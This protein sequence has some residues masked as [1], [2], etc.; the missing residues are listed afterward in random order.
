MKL[1][2]AAGETI[3]VNESDL[4]A[5]TAVSGSGPAYVFYLAEAMQRAAADLG[6]ARHAPLLVQQTILGAARLMRQSDE[7]PEQLRHK[8]TSP[9]GTTEAAIRHLD[10]N[11]TTDVIIN[12]IKAARAQSV[13]LG[14]R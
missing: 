3:L 10:G 4:D 11:K 12:A 13:A 8:V 9:G 14:E 2:G 1:F 7:T 6:L 5:I